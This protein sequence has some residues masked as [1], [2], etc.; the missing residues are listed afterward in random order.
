MDNGGVTPTLVYDGDCGFCSTCVRFVERRLRTSATIVAWQHADL[1][2]LDVRQEDAERAVQWIASDGRRS[3]GAA[4][5]AKLF[6]D[7]GWPWRALGWVMLTPPISWC[8][9]LVYRLV[10][11]NRHRMPGGTPACAL[12]PPDRR[13]ASG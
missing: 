12:P 1:D 7:S 5:V 2:A 8:A 11:N 3:A 13:P 6:V 9:A 10:A 4:A